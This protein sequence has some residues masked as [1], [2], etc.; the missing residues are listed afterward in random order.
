[1]KKFLATMLIG[2]FVFA[3][4]SCHIA[5]RSE[6]K[7]VATAFKDITQMAEAVEKY[8]VPAEEVVPYIY[9]VSKAMAEK[10]DAENEF[11]PTKTS[12]QIYQGHIIAKEHN[13]PNPALEEVLVRT[14]EN[15]DDIGAIGWSAILG[16][17]L[18]GL[19]T[20]GKF[21]GG[22]YNIAGMALQAIGQRFVPDYDKVK[23]AAVGAIASFDK[24]LADYGEMLDAAPETKKML[25]E[26]LGKDPVEWMKDNLRRAQTDLGATE[27]SNIM[28]IMKSQMTTENG[29]LKPTAAE[30]DK[31][32][33]KTLS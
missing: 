24:V 17:V 2:L 30:I 13:I 32:L 4:S 27:V 28:N 23:K 9:K 10:M 15:M 16:G 3:V 11:E 25:T 8:D 6:E 1:M 12:Y 7:A 26:K 29:I 19:G 21:M 31:F 33:K 18:L 22:P 5:W 14:K 20:L